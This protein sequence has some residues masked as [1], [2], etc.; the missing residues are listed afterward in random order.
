MSQSSELEAIKAHA[1]RETF[2][3]EKLYSVHIYL[4]KT[5]LT[6]SSTTLVLSVGFKTFINPNKEFVHTELLPF[7]WIFLTACVV[8]QMF[9]IR[10][11]LDYYYGCYR[12]HMNDLPEHNGNVYKSENKI[13]LFN[14]ISFWAWLIG[15]SLILT[16]VYENLK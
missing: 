2:L 12:N 15:L 7:G 10:H 11:A 3:R 13:I 14:R 1:E 5:L 8:L 4:S 6:L 9:M 16:F